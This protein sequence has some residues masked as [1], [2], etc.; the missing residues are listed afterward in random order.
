MTWQVKGGDPEQHK[1]YHASIAAVRH[2]L[3][4]ADGHL[5]R[6]SSTSEIDEKRRVAEQ[7]IGS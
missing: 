2:H 4:E 5:E 7:P 6:N 1:G 3:E